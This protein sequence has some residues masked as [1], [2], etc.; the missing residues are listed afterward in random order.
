MPELPEVETIAHKLAT[1]V[2]GKTIEHILVH[3]SK[4][5]QGDTALLINQPIVSI[6]RRAKI[7]CIQFPNALNL[8][9]HLKMTGQL[10]Y[11]DSNTRLGGGHPTA[12]WVSALPSSHT[13]IEMT[14]SDNA[15]LFFNDMRLFGWWK[16]LTDDQVQLE[17]ARLAPDIID[18]TLTSTYLHDRFLKTSMPIKGALMDTRFVSGVGNIYACDALNLARINPWRIARSLQTIETEALFV[19]AKTVIERGIQL[20]GATIDAYRNVEGFS[21]QYQDVVLVYGRE[22]KPCYNCGAL[23]Q[24][25]KILGRGTYFCAQCQV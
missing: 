6:S 2:V 17:L 18:P 25:A 14:F 4:S 7:I 16:V 23:I 15:K 1:H 20:G 22:G 19:A 10:I 12:D 21:G 9:I 13:R 24:K 8:L 5:F 11:T 3:H